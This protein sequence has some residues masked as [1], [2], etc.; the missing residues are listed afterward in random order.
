MQDAYETTGS[1]CE[2][3]PATT[4][5]SA[6]ALVITQSFKDKWDKYA[7]GMSDVELPVIE[8]K[9]RVTEARA[10]DGTQAKPTSTCALATEQV[11]RNL[12]RA[13]PANAKRPTSLTTISP[14]KSSAGVKRKGWSSASRRQQNIRGEKRGKSARGLGILQE[15]MPDAQKPL[16]KRM[17]KR[18]VRAAKRE[19]REKAAAAAAAAERLPGSPSPIE[20]PM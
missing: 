3:A 19:E 15:D 18:A 14:R 1:A 9:A 8:D 17:A 6:A 13:E 4:A 2:S 10:A 16:S 7:E 11:P 12:S 5:A 20:K